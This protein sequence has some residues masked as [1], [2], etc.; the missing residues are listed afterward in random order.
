MLGAF[1]AVAHDPTYQ[2]SRIARFPTCH[3][4][5]EGKDGLWTVESCCGFR[6]QRVLGHFAAGAG[7]VEGRLEL[8][9]GQERCAVTALA[10]VAVAS[11]RQQ[12]SR[13]H[14]RIR[15]SGQRARHVITQHPGKAS[16]RLAVSCRPA[17]DA[18]LQSRVCVALRD[19]LRKVGLDGEAEVTPASVTARAA[20]EAFEATGRIEESARRLGV[21]SLDRAAAVVGY[22]WQGDPRC[23]DGGPADA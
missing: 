13:G 1:W 17:N 14:R 20:V 6:V 7:F 19:L 16:A 4:P 18:A 22:D 2:G 11:A 15:R 10:A 21:R 9:V 12:Q 8:G 5:D 23:S 3:T